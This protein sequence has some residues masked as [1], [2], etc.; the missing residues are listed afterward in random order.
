MPSVFLFVAAITVPFD[1]RDLFQDRTYEL[2]TIPVMLGE[3]KAYFICLLLLII[4]LV[5]L[6]LF[7]KQFDSNF[8]GLTLTIILTV[9]LIFK[10][11]WERN[12]Y[13]YFFFS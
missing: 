11:E 6:F 8:I 1:I 5:L 4:Y 7:N 13:Y 9:W 3:R 12:E 2:K 10:S